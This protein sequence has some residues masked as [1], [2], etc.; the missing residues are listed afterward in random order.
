MALLAG[1]QPQMFAFHQIQWIYFKTPT[2]LKASGYLICHNRMNNH[3]QEFAMH[4]FHSFTFPV[5]SDAFLKVGIFKQFLSGESFQKV[6][7]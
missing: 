4:R 1:I 5:H 3:F 7:F 6:A 2:K